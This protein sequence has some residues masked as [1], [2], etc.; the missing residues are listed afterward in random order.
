MNLSPMKPDVNDKSCRWFE[1]HA[2]LQVAHSAQ[3]Q[4]G[5]ILVFLQV[6]NQASVQSL[7]IDGRDP[8]AKKINCYWGVEVANLLDISQRR[9]LFSLEAE[10][11]S[12]DPEAR[13]ERSRR[14]GDWGT[15]SPTHMVARIA[16]SRYVISQQG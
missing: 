14:V 13:G 16:I 5:R 11:R 15:E 6:S 12:S 8:S 3:A 9:S 2:G 4:L 7:A 1:K 10:Y